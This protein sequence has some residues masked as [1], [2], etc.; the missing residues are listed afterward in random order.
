MITPTRS[1]GKSLPIYGDGLQ[2]QGLALSSAITASA[3]SG[4]CSS[5]GRLGRDIQHRRQQPTQRI[6]TLW[7][8]L[9]A[10]LDELV[11]GSSQP[12]TQAAHDRR[13]EDR[14]G[15]DRR[16]AINAT[17][18]SSELHWQPAE[19]F[20]TGLRRTVE[21]YLANTAWTEHV[22]SGE[23]QHWIAANYSGRQ[24]QEARA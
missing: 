8:T 16:Y 5:S 13:C 18:I 10:L 14:P 9:C 6:S 17:K 12:Y 1:A 7:T 19:T 22:T 24:Q 2:V 23:Y 4:A 21:W 15:H 3:L 20:T 11:P